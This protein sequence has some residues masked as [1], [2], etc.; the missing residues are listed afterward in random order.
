MKVKEQGCSGL[1]FALNQR[2]AWEAVGSEGE[3]K[4]E[5]RPGERKAGDVNVQHA[6]SRKLISGR[7]KKLEL[8]S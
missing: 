8:S 1:S 4:G 7:T 5:A 2:E 6:C 3:G